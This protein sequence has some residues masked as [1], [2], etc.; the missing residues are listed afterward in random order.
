MRVTRVITY[1]G[2]AE[3]ITKVLGKSLADGDKYSDTGINAIKISVLTLGSKPLLEAY[4]SLEDIQPKQDKLIIG[5][6]CICPD[7]LG[8]VIDFDSS[9]GIQVQT[10]INNR[11]C[12]WDKN[13]VELLPIRR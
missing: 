7:G 11:N 3:A 12:I 10:Y 1:E 4:K 6:E 2:S 8:R 13:N 5:Q 9:K